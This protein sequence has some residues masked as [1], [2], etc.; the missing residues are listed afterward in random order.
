MLADL[1]KAAVLGVVEGVTEFLP[2]SSTGHLIL[3]DAWVKFDPQIRVVFDIFIQ[4]GA[5][6]AVVWLYRVRLLDSV[7]AWSTRGRDLWGKLLLAFV[8]AGVT[9]FLF[10]HAIERVLF[11]PP[12]VAA[13]LVA[14]GV[15]MIV[16]ERACR[17]P[18]VRT[19][20]QIS[21]RHALLIG[22]AQCLALVPGMSRSACTIL[23]GMAA[24]L[25]AGVA[26]EFSFLLAIP[27]MFAAGGYSL[28]KN[29]SLLGGRQAALLAVGTGV[30]FIVA[31]W[32]VS[33]FV[34]YLQ[35]R[36]LLPFA[37]YRIVLGAALLLARL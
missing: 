22:L 12:S 5:V 36:P 31:F 7:R 16:V 18:G 27:T 37:V 25:S 35:T 14:G 19:L 21:Y 32:V 6:A 23:G 34:R 20:E 1:F 3:V 9:G 15:L 4:L 10:H 24:G 26:A 17:N 13:A 11:N 29:L 33:A 30:S 8:P 28:L 2:V